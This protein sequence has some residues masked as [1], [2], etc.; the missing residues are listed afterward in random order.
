MDIG[1]EMYKTDKVFNNFRNNSTS[2][3]VILVNKEKKYL[4][5]EESLLQ[6]IKSRHAQPHKSMADAR[7]NS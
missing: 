7:T 2:L 1:E 5:T 3:Q 6:K 4:D